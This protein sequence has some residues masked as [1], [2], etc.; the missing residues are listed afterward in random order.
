MGGGV[1]ARVAV[2]SE[3]DAGGRH[4][5]GAGEAAGPHQARDGVGKQHVVVVEEQQPLALGRRRGGVAG[6]AQVAVLLAD[7]PPAAGGEVGLDGVEG[8]AGRGA[9]AAVVDQDRVEAGVVLGEHAVGRHAQQGRAL[10]VDEADGDPRRP[11]RGV[12]RAVGEALA[13]GGE[14]AGLGV[15]ALPDV[16]GGGEVAARTDGAQRRGGQRGEPVAQGGVVGRDQ[17]A[18]RS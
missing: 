15:P 8:G 5:V 11:G 2:A 10:V 4:A 18:G 6:R 17:G 1:G 16:E 14:R 12:P 3:A 7:D 13:G 9:L